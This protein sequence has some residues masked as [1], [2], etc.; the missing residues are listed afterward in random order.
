MKTDIKKHLQSRILLL[1]GA[2]GTMVQQHKLQESDFRGERFANHTSDLKGNNDLL[3]LVRPDIIADIHRA[4]LNAGSDIIETNTFNANSVSQADYGLEDL[5]FELNHASAQ[6]A[7][8]VADEVTQQNVERPRFVAGSIGPTSKTASIATNVDDPSFRDIHFDQLIDTYSVA[9]HGLVQGG[10]DLLLVETVTDG[11]NCKAALYA[12]DEY[13]L[14][15]NLTLPIMVSCTIFPDQDG[16]TLAGQTLEAFYNTIRHARPISIGLNCAT[17]AQ[18][19]R[20]FI[21][22]LHLIAE[23]A[24]SLHPNAGLPNAFDGYDET[25]EQMAATL[26]EYA[27]AGLLN[28]VGGCCGTS[29]DYISAIADAVRNCPPRQTPEIEHAC[30][31]SGL[32]ALNIK[33]D[34]LFVNVGERT[35]VTGSA[36]F[37]RLIKSEDYDAALDVARAQVENGAQIIDI[38]MD[39]GMLDSQQAMINFLQ[40]VGSEPDIARV[41]IMLDSSEWCVIEAGLKCLQGKGVVN[42]I[43]MKEG[44]AAFIERARLVRRY[45]AA[46]VVMAFDEDG[47]AD[48]LV[49][50]VAICT[51]AYRILVDQV[52]FPPED[53]IFDPNIFAVATGIA[54]HNTYGADFIEATRQIKQTLPHVKISGGLSNVSFSFRGNNTV[55]EAIHSV[56]LYHTIK[57][58]LDMAIVN[59]GQLAI[60]EEIDVD[61]RERI[62]DVLFNR[63]EDAAD[64]LLEAASSLQSV[65]TDEKQKKDE[66]WR[67]ESVE[68]RIKHAMVKGISTYIVEDAEAARNK[69][70]HPIDVI[71]G[72]L[73]DA[74]NVVGTLFG[75]GKMFLPQVV[76]SARVMKQAVAYLQPFIEEARTKN[77]TATKRKVLIATVKGDV[78]DIGKNIVSVVLQCNDYQIIDLGVMVPCATLLAAARDEKVDMIGLSGL[79]TPSLQEM[80]MVA[81]E[82]ERLGFDIPLLIG[83]ATTSKV[84]TAVKIAP[85]YHGVTVHVR[86][87]SRGVSVVS[88]LLNQD[89]KT[90][91]V[92]SIAAEYETLRHNHLQKSQK[93]T[94]YSI[95]EARRHGLP[96]DW[97]KYTPPLPRQIGL[98]SFRKYPL[99]D[100][101][102]FIDWGPFFKVW[103]LPGRYPDILQDERVGKQARGIFKDA[104]QLLDQ[105]IAKRWLQAQAVFGLFP[106]NAIADD[107]AVYADANRLEPIG[108]IHNLRQQMVK[109]ESRPN[110]CLADFIAPK[111]SGV[112]DYVGFFAVTAGIGVD[113]CVREFDKDQNDYDSI[114]VKAVADRLTEALAEHLHWR[115]R[116]EFWGY[117]AD[118]SLNSKDLIDEKYRGI[119]PAPGYASCP[120]HTEKALLAHLLNMQENASI[121]LTENFAMLPAASISGYYFSH[122]QAQ[123]FATG[124]IERDQVE[125]Y[126]RRKGMTV[127]E[128]EK[129]LAPVLGY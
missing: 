112:A 100:L 89:K 87:A 99:A 46:V 33:S 84:H 16:R 40:L 71:E 19:L 86:D 4:Y 124:K 31:L 111:A 37:A 44:E 80:T 26:G 6:V 41:P 83:G 45:G 90:E 30:R 107:I 50:K 60:Y 62:E 72:P 17:G 49:R 94:R 97:T 54:E 106:A 101:R 20:P 52:G 35:N 118:E 88:S 9:I 27:N 103:D 1:D 29:P 75:D 126:A 28:I 69:Y 34:S 129:W 81:K 18:T 122:P 42:S 21:Q 13:F 47:Q 22:E 15:H 64:R 58:G 117:A 36:R 114:M 109:P 39:E 82:M 128:V 38:N 32:E 70:N 127:E 102:D 63:R 51:R 95:A 55:R 104:N 43:S 91:F 125:D 24:I 73:M 123:Y 53:I 92:A 3:S 78:H 110:H 67:R 68:E 116:T 108:I 8:R 11:L 115:V 66:T 14:Q 48:T 61:L 98:Q 119:R 96:I 2:M 56:F 65:S 105:I 76:K 120:D 7:R 85:H 74:M 93:A 12:I 23:T 57:A 59:A 10:V 121:T 5:V 77:S 113:Q 25:P 79:I